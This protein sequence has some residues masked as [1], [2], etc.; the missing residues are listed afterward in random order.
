SASPIEATLSFTGNRGT[1]HIGADDWPLFDVTEAG[2]KV[3]FTL[4]IPGTPYVTVHYSGNLAGDG[5][6][7][8]SLNEGQ[9]V[10][11]LTARRAGSGQV[12]P[13]LAPTPE[14]PAP[15]PFRQSE[16]PVALLNPPPAPPMAL[17]NPAPPAPATPQ[18]ASATPP[19][20]PRAP[21]P[22]P[23]V[24]PSARPALNTELPPLRE[25]PPNNLAK[26]PLMG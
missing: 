2:T 23:M 22:A 1:M 25:V 3:A 24:Q 9:G 15:A 4:V 8:T 7:L 26:T 10:F 13:Q 5:L 21:P 20:L 6:E 11:K 14:R 16:P 19:G 12:A 17:L 18:A